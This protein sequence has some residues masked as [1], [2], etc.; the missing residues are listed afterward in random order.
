MG[1][2]CNCFDAARWTELQKFLA[3]YFSLICKAFECTATGMR[4]TGVGWDPRMMAR[5]NIRYSNISLRRNLV[6]LYYN[7]TRLSLCINSD[8]ST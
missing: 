4:A 6:L 2:A 7:K 3:D 1:R 5:L 8:S